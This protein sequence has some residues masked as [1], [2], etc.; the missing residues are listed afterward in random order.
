LKVTPDCV[1]LNV[2]VAPGSVVV[3][4]GLAVIDGAGGAGGVAEVMTQQYCVPPLEFP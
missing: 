2:K 1:S 4:P 3:A